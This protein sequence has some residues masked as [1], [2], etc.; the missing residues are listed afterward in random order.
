[1]LSGKTPAEVSATKFVWAWRWLLVCALLGAIIFWTLLPAFTL[2][3]VVLLM[4]AYKAASSILKFRASAGVGSH[5][6]VK[7]IDPRLRVQHA[8]KKLSL[9]FVKRSLSQSKIR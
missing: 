4:V 9:V 1:M 5:Y 6:D 7:R 8:Q 3:L 2:L